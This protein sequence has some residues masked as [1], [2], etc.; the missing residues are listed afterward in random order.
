[1]VPVL[2]QLPKP[3]LIA[4]FTIVAVTRL[5]QMA[6]SPRMIQLTVAIS[7]RAPF[8]HI[9]LALSSILLLVSLVQL[10]LTPR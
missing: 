8:E 9:V 10:S 5:V 1:M 7:G 4:A 6:C 2:V 3:G